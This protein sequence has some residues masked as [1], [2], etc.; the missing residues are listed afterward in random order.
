LGCFSI[1]NSNDG[2]GD[3]RRWNQKT[4][5]MPI[6]H[7]LQQEIIQV[8]MALDQTKTVGKVFLDGHIRFLVH[9]TIHN[10]CRILNNECFFVNKTKKQVFANLS[11]GSLRPFDANLFCVYFK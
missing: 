1:I 11:H 2:R 8:H 3:D 10:F 7:Q 9:T 4:F 6:Q 5:C